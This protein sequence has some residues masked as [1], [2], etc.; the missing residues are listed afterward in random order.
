MF[1]GRLSLNLVLVLLLV[2]SVSVFREVMYISFIASIRSNLTHLCGLS[3]ACAAAIFHRNHVFC[4][5]QQNKSD[6]AYA[7][8]IKEYITSQKLGSWEFWQIANT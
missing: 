3:A 5:Y 7:T 8:K 2:N 4:L 1:H 6:F